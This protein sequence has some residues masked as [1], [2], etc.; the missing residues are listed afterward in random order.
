MP[1]TFA[2][3]DYALGPNL[4]SGGDFSGSMSPWTTYFTS[5]T[6]RGSARWVSAMN[7]CTGGCVELTSAKLGDMLSSP[8]FSLTGGTLYQ[9]RYT[10]VYNANGTV[11]EP[12]IARTVS[13]WDSMIDAKGHKANVSRTGVVGRVSN[14]EAFF[15]AKTS[16]TAQVN[17]QIATAY[18]PIAFDNVSLRAVLGYRFA[19][20][21]QWQQ[22]VWAGAGAT[23]VGCA[24]LGWD[25]GCSVTDHNGTPVALPVTVAAGESRLFLRLDSEWKR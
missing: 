18:A 10:A 2:L 4:L 20:A 14:F 22:L 13:P 25:S 15:T 6:P 9:Y 19:E 7:G 17:L 1:L 24:S 5:S 21:S 12:Y 23:T 11:G 16:A 3:S 8:P